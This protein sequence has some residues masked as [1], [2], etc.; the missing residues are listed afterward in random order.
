MRG[1]QEEQGK[2]Q[3]RAEVGAEIW[4]EAGGGLQREDLQNNGQ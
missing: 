1:A 2:V 4:V 3:G